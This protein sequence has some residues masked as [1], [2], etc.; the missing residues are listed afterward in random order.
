MTQIKREQILAA[1]VTTLANT[2]GV[3]TRIYRS[4]QEAFARAEAPCLLIEPGIDVPSDDPV[5]TCKIDWTLPVDITV[6]TRG[7]IPEQ[8]AAPIIDSLHGK[9]MA[10]ETLG[11]LAMRIWPGPVNHQRE[12]ADATAGWTTCTY[13]V[14]YRTSVTDL[15]A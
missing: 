10:D 13:T 8:L 7:A 2:T 12:Q 3:S 9:L 6:H 15:K 11:G 14:R 1:I 4:R 5:S